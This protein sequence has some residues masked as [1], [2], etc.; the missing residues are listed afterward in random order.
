MGAVLGEGGLRHG[1]GGW[2]RGG[3]GVRMLMSCEDD[4]ARGGWLL[5]GM[6]VLSMGVGDDWWLKKGKGNERNEGV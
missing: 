5:S 6:T 2:L 3:G 1:A 4:V